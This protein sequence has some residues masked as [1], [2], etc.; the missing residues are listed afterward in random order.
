MRT[1][2]WRTNL[3]F[4]TFMVTTLSQCNSVCPAGTAP[5]CV[6]TAAEH[7]LVTRYTKE[8]DVDHWL[9]WHRGCGKGYECLWDA[10][11][12]A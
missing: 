2:S 4:T 3:L 9:A 8:F 12:H 6:S 1:H 10:D 7:E 11:H 5:A